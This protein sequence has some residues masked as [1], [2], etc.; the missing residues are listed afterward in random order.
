MNCQPASG[1]TDVIEGKGDLADAIVFDKDSP[2]EILPAGQASSDALGLV[3]SSAMSTVLK[4]LSGHYDYII[5]D[6]PPIAA[7][8]DA[9]ILS[10]EADT[11]LLVVRCSTTPANAVQYALRVLKR[12]G[13][14]IIGTVLTMV[15]ASYSLNRKYGYF[16]YY[17]YYGNEE[18]A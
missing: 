14:H 7:A 6:S 2:L 13:G 5:I 16:G 1:L 9:C 4:G 8:P 3:E 12:N 15:E 10:R 11:T 17:G 18:T